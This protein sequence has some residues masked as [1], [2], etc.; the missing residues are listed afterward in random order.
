MTAIRVKSRMS[1]RTKEC[2][3]RI[4]NIS[5]LAAIQCFE[6]WGI[7]CA[8]KAARDM[9][10]AVLAKELEVEGLSNTVKVLSYAPGITY[11]L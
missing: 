6:S 5:S 9:Y 10:Y 4:V 1:N 3:F 8:G 11:S 7:Y 2:Q